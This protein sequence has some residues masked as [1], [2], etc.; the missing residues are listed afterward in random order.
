MIENINFSYAFGEPLAKGL[1][2]QQVD[3]FQV[4]EN[5]GWSPEGQGE[6]IYLDVTKRGENTGW[7]AKKIA[8]FAGVT[9]KDIGY[10]GLKD[11]KAVTRQ[12]FSIYCPKGFEGS[13]DN[14]AQLSSSDVIIHQ[15]TRGQKKLKRGSHQ[16]NQFKIVIRGLEN[17]N[18]DELA[19]RMSLVK[20]NGVPNYFGDQRFGRG[21]SNLHQAQD[22]VNQSSGG[23]PKKNR[24]YVMSAARSLLF[25]IVL[26][27][28]VQSHCWNTLIEGDFE[29]DGMPTAPM[30]GRGRT[31]VHDQCAQLEASAL[32]DWQD[33]CLALEHSGLKQE[34][35][36]CVLKPSEL[37]WSLVDDTC[38]V[39]FNLPTGCFATTFLREIF[40]LQ[41]IE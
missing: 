28:R 24:S 37:E 36:S 13:W 22:W 8:E 29:L 4:V 39:E 31:I 41:S 2:K 12:W 7:V 19:Q 10:S 23:K 34:R 33:W 3:D 30:W 6:H 27:Q 17:L 18:N 21:F 40:N 16:S 26:N 38:T 11:R 32:D 20:Q 25:N 9:E 15:I 5:L 14:F 35:R 1:L